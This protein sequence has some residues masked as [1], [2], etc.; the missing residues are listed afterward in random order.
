M[1]QEEDGLRIFTNGAD[2]RGPVTQLKSP[3]INSEVKQACL[4]AR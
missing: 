1:E 3:T 4:S 2:K